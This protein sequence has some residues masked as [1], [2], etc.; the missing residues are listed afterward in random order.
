MRRTQSVEV[1]GIGNFDIYPIKAQEQKFNE[2]SKE[3]KPLKKVLVKK[4]ISA[5]YKWLDEDKA[6]HN[7]EEVFFDV[8]GNYVQE[9]KRTEKVKNFEIVDKTEIYN[10]SESSI[11]V[12][13]CDETTQKLFDEKIKDSAIRFNIKKSSRG[14]KWN[15]AYILKMREVLVMVNGLGDIEKAITEFKDESIAKEEIDVIV[16]KVEMK[17]ED[18]EQQIL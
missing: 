4:G 17:A 6:E 13:N 18:L 1:I 10:L 9:V 16:Q 8:L 11:S 14:F 3:G 2:V 5:E 7:K 15:K 12:L